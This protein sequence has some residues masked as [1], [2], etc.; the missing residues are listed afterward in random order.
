M[1]IASTAKENTMKTA[2]KVTRFVR[3]TAL[4]GL[5]CPFVCAS[6][7]QKLDVF[8]LPDMSMIIYMQKISSAADRMQPIAVSFL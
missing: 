6:Q 7:L 5:N 2:K 8:A 3:V 4:S 1:I